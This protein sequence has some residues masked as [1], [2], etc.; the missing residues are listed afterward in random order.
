MHKDILYYVSDCNDNVINIPFKSEEEA[1]EYAKK[2]NIR[3]FKII[4]WE[5]D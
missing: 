5:V 1:V 3:G 4:P 2:E